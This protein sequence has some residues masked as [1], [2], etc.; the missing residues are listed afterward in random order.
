MVNT[1]K[2]TEWNAEAHENQGCVEVFV[3]LLHIVGIVLRRLLFVHCVEIDLGIVAFDRLEIHP[4]SRLDAVWSQ[5]VAPQS[6]GSGTHHRGSTLTG[7]TLS[8]PPIVIFR[9][10]VDERGRYSREANGIRPSYIYGESRRSPWPCH[11]IYAKQQTMFGSTLIWAVFGLTPVI[12]KGGT[13]GFPIS[14]T[15]RSSGIPDTL[16][17]AANGPQFPGGSLACPTTI[18]RRR[19]SASIICE[20]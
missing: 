5:L 16:L 12:V 7:F 9:H 1:Y 6:Q 10:G 13:K 11:Q 3:I 14:I 8:S 19:H 15:E 2:A 17:T 18:A 20:S 4:E